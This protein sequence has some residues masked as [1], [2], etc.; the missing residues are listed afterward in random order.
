MV[1]PNASPQ[2]DGRMTM[3]ARYRRRSLARRF[4]TAQKETGESSVAAE[5]SPGMS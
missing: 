2:D 4:A 3:A 1:S 5:L